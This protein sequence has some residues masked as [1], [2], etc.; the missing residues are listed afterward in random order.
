[1]DSLYITSG[2]TV[3]AQACDTM[4]CIHYGRSPSK[5]RSHTGIVAD[6]RSPSSEIVRVIHVSALLKQLVI[7]HI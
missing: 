3:E 6:S 7:E 2:D 5:C 4:Y 1:M